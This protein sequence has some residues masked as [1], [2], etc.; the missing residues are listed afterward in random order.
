MCGTDRQG[1]HTVVTAM[2]WAVPEL[3]RSLDELVPGCSV[4]VLPSL[5]STNSELMRRARAGVAAPVL[6]V[7]ECQTAGRGRLGRSWL[8]GAAAQHDMP[9]PA[10][11]ALPAL[12]FSIGLPMAPQDW[13]G[14]SLAVG[15]GVACALHPALGLKWPNDIWLHERKLAGILVETA[16]VGAVRYVVVGIGI[17]IAP[18]DPAGL[19]TPPAWLQELLPELD[20]PAVLARL[21]LPLMQVLR[22]F[23]AQGFAPFRAAFG[24]RDVLRGR[25]VQLSDGGTGTA[26]GV[27]A[28]GALLVHAGTG[29][30]LVHSAEVSVRPV[31]VRTQE[32]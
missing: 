9:L 11:A 5:D 4:E 27:D 20:A 14:L 22:Q 29:V 2:R 15:V 31:S 19:S 30:K 23:E 6:L 1:A 18:R 25:Q 12:T 13:S 32:F 21:A 26:A 17:N 28:H 24:Q 10:A 8:S 7:A 3:R 16:A